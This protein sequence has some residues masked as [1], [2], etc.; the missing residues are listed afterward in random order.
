[1]EAAANDLPVESRRQFERLGDFV[2]DRKE[3]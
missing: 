1:M 3:R 2:T